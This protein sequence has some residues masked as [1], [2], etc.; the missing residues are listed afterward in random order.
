MTQ[1]G[2]VPATLIFCVYLETVAYLWQSLT[3]IFPLTCSKISCLLA[4]TAV[5]DVFDFIST[6]VHVYVSVWGMSTGDCE[7]PQGDTRGSW[8]WG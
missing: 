8:S 1:S 4:Q 2:S 6:Y 7:K 5:L 3:V